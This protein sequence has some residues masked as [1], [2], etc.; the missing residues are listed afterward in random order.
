MLANCAGQKFETL[1]KVYPPI[2]VASLFSSI[3]FLVLSFVLKQWQ[4]L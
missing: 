4:V 1:G 2:S 3:V